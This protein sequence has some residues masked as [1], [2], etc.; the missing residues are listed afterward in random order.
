MRRV[1]NLL[2]AALATAAVFLAP[3]G[4]GTARTPVA[5]AA[6]QPSTPL[7]QPLSFVENRGQA[8][9]RFAYYADWGGSSLFF[10]TRGV[11]FAL[12]GWAVEQAFVGARAERGA[13]REPARAGTRELV[14]G[15][16]GG[17]ADR[18]R[19]LPHAGIPARMAGHRRPLH[20]PRQ[21]PRDQLSDPGR[22]PTLARSSSPTAERRPSRSRPPE[23]SRSRRP[24]ES[25]SSSARSPISASPGTASRCA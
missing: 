2:G 6:I 19:A 18:P 15:S 8:D 12:D 24:Q 1:T 20:G 13:A 22:A 10:T 4:D 21:R 7:R 14:C 25:S 5:S 3:L 9:R 16:A 17:V 23:G 11:M